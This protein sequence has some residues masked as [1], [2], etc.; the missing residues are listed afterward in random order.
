[1][2][3]RGCPGHLRVAREASKELTD[4]RQVRQDAGGGGG[5]GRVGGF[6]AWGA[7]GLMVI[8]VVEEWNMRRVYDSLPSNLQHNCTPDMHP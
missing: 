4:K 3:L 2:L 1:M 8:V 6:K 5:G 7:I